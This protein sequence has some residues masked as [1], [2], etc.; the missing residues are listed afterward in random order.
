MHV[1]VS[2]SFL[3]MLLHSVLRLDTVLIR[4]GMQLIREWMIQSVCVVVSLS[5]ACAAPCR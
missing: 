1:L 4:M 5:W 3:S 2:I